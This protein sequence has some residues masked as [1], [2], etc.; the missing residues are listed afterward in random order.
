[1]T[2]PK[3][4]LSGRQDQL[5]EVQDQLKKLI[6]SDTPEGFK[7]FFSAINNR[8][9]IPTAE[10][11]QWIERLYKS[12]ADDEGFLQ[13]AFRFSWKTTILTVAFLAYRIGL[14]PNK[15]N[16]LIQV[17]D[18]SAEGT[19]KK[20]A[21]IILTNPIWKW[22]FPTIVPD[23]RRGWGN[24][25]YF[26][27]DSSMDYGEWL[28]QCGTDPSFVGYGYTSDSI[29]GKHPNGCLIVDDIHNEDNTASS[30]ELKR[31][32]DILTGTIFPTID[33][34][35]TWVIFV[36]TPWVKNDVLGYLKATGVF[37]C[38]V[39][40]IYSEV[41]GEK[42]YIWPERYDEVEVEK[43][44]SLSGPVEFPRMYLCDISAAEGLDLKREWL[45]YYPQ[46]KLKDT[47]PVW[48]GVDFASLT[49][50][51]H[52]TDYDYFAMAIGVE[53]PGVG[54]VLVD[55]CYERLSQAEAKQR[56]ELFRRKYPTLQ[57]IGFENIGGG[58]VAL[59]NYLVS[60]SLPLLPSGVGNKSKAYRYGKVLAPAFQTGRIR[61]CETPNPFLTAFRAE[62]LEYPIGDHDDAL[63]AVF[64]LAKAAIGPLLAMDFAIANLEE[65]DPRIA[66]NSIAQM[67]GET[68]VSSKASK[69]HSPWSGLNKRRR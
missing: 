37:N 52:P 11:D 4:S 16:L 65:Q 43:L 28:R 13:E 18:E 60:S 67:L 26:V 39:T 20:V 49:D 50:P 34:K 8:P 59:E 22:L 27:K 23:E 54:L 32:I 69:T 53:V 9:F 42:I 40:K 19:A 5:A 48:G 14:E 66:K 3:E 44:R 36:G 35:S 24:K 45:I 51:L 25:G 58:K 46:D 31:C 41:N 2:L 10:K 21:D 6:L 17:K 7:A 38:G 30:K 29:I 68:R 63:D 55:G 15:T 56:M 1:L 62:W 61:L 57:A 47:W 12:H 64:H 33:P